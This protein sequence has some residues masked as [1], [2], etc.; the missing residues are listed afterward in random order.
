MAYKALTM[1]LAFYWFVINKKVSINI[2]TAGEVI[3]V[4]MYK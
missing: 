4:M 2:S 3:I 1:N